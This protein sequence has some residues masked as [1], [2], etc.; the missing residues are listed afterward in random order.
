MWDTREQWSRLSQYQ[1]DQRKFVSFTL[2]SLLL[3]SGA[4]FR[5]WSF[6][7]FLWASCLRDY[8]LQNL[9]YYIFHNWVDYYQLSAE[10]LQELADSDL[11]VETYGLIDIS[12]TIN[13]HLQK[14][15]KKY[16][17]Y[18]GYAGIGRGWQILTLL[19]AMLCTT[20]PSK[21]RKCVFST[22]F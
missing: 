18:L 20:I 3:E 2:G 6:Y 17:K 11:K 22:T 5:A 14:I 4:T 13:P 12:G 16:S 1:W 19:S 10:T 9:I 7:K 15:E 8:L 21:K